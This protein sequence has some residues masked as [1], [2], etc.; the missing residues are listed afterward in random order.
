MDQL[1][2]F[3]EAAAPRVAPVRPIEAW[4]KDKGTEAHWLAAAKYAERW[5]I[6]REVSEDVFDAAIGAVKAVSLR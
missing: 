4:A 2:L 3:P 5:G 6:G 1:E